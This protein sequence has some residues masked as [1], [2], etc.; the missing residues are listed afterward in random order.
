MSAT[1][2]T[3]TDIL[4]NST[5]STAS[6]KY[7]LDNLCYDNPTDIVNAFNEYF[8]N[9]GPLQASKIQATDVPFHSFLSQPCD[10]TFFLNPT[11]TN[12]VLKIVN[13]LK[14]S[15]AS[16]HD[17]VS[18]SLLKQI[19]MNIVT[20]LTFLLNL[21]LSTGCFPECFKLAKVIPIHKKDDLT[22]INNYRPI[23]LLSSFSKILERIVYDRLYNFLSTN[24][25]LSPCQ[26]GFRKSYSTDLA[27]ID[28]CDKISR[29]LADK[30]HVLGV[31]MDLSKAFDTLDHK[32]LLYK[33]K[34]YG[35]RGICYKWFESYLSNR[36]QFVSHL[37]TNSATLPTSCGVPQGSI[38]GPL[39]FLIY[40]NDICSVSNVLQFIL[41]ADDTNVFYSDPNFER[42]FA[43]MN[44][45]LPKL[46]TW[47]RSNKL[48]LNLIKTNYIH[49][50]NPQAPK[51]DN[52][53]DLIIDNVSL[54]P[55]ENTKFLGVT[56]DHYLN[57]NSHIE[58]ITVSV[59]RGIGV[60]YKLRSFL[61]LRTLVIVY[62]SIILSHISYC[63]LVWACQKSKLNEIYTLQKKA[64]RICT[65]SNYLAHSDPLFFQTS[66]LPVSELHDYQ[67][68]LFM[69]RFQTND[70]PSSFNSMFCLNSS[71]HNYPT[72]TSL[73]IHLTNPKTS[74][75]HRSIRHTGPDM[76]NS[77]PPDVISS[78]SKSTFKLRMKKMLLMKYSA[79]L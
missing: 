38:L 53:P 68:A 9:I 54:E 13:S 37:S 30:H 67:I 49:F 66:I 3:I 46:S 69:Y 64:V 71:I 36:T 75:A 74:L 39:L 42:L 79:E 62:N 59:S 55:K 5:S 33:L 51:I 20:P 41:Y 18:N 10:K 73:N 78:S 31:F 1:W 61:P 40:V 34:H 19:I 48:S 56:I 2:R 52:Y 14:S 28:L 45:E 57:W 15:K 26:F 8:A 35:L 47:F 27:L 29:S 22:C 21:S 17:E 70:L 43:V 25:L 24:F 6:V 44:E 76:W 32:I 4:G 72:R 16:G 11:D 23:S 65:N 58:N 50:K 77:L 7:K 63:N 60:L 12:E